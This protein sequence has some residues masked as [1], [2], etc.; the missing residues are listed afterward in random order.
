MSGFAAEMPDDPGL[1]AIDR[2]A[3]GGVLLHLGG[4]A[5]VGQH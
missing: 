2:D 1:A 3:Q 5:F 4:T